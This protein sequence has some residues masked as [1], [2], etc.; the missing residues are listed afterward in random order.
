VA[1]AFA[2]FDPVLFFLSA[3]TS[4]LG[5]AN[6]VPKSLEDLK[7][8]ITHEVAAIPPEMT[9]TVMSVYQQ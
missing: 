1:A 9:R 2:R 5:Y 7:E 8:A 4:Q 6:I 3:A